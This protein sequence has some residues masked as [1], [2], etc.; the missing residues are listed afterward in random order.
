[1]LAVTIVFTLPAGAFRSIERD[2]RFDA[3]AL[4]IDEAL[5]L[6]AVATDVQVHTQSGIVRLSDL[7]KRK[8]TVLLLAYYSC[9]HSCPTTI[10]NLAETDAETSTEDYEVLVLSFDPRDTLES[11]E[12]VQATLPTVPDNWTFGLLAQGENTRLTDSIGFN[13]YFSEK[14]QFFVHP[15]VLI[16]LTPERQVTRYLY[17]ARPRAKD[18]ELALTESRIGQA[19]LNDFVDMLM[20]T[21]FQFDTSQSRYV[22]HPTILFGGAG[23]GVLGLVGLVTLTS[24]KHSRGAF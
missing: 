7:T 4:Q 14:D 15:A 18:V 17:G 20:L 1:M 16:F 21:C 19:R 12:A 6:G 10:R 13:F 5:Y 22:I 3:G 8:P 23:L 11:L 24:R 9:G 2:E